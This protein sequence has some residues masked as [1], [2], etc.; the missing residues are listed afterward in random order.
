MKKL[1][2]FLFV[3]FVLGSVYAAEPDSLLFAGNSASEPIDKEN[4]TCKG[5]KL[6]GKVQVVESFADFDVRVVESF[7]DLDV[8]AVSSFADECGEWEFVDSSPDFTV[9]FVDSFSDFDI[10]FVNSFPGVR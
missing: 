8:T 4:C 2:S 9:R 1:L 5:K 6:Y 3:L 7:A 10:R